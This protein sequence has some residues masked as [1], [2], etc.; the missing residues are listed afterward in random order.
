MKLYGITGWKDQGKTT[1]VEAL[2]A[3]FVGTG[4]RVSTIKHTHHGVDLDEPGRDSY[5]HREAGAL[6]V[7]LA[8]RRRFALLHELRDAPELELEDLVA[9]M[10]PVDLILVEG[11]KMTQHPKLEVYRSAAARDRLPLADTNPSIRALVG[12]I[13]GHVTDLPVFDP[14]DVAAIAAHILQNA[15]EI[16][17]ETG[18]PLLAGSAT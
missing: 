17:P 9:R 16:G 4:L 2:V 6:Q 18:I 10:D 5:R 15:L 12:D 13:G 8:S 3:Y 14:A 11:Y 7:V 1:L